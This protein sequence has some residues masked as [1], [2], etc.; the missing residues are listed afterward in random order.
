MFDQVATALMVGLAPTPPARS[1][2]QRRVTLWAPRPQ[3]VLGALA[4]LLAVA[5]FAYLA[6]TASQQAFSAADL[7]IARWVRALDLPGLNA[8]FLPPQLLPGRS[9]SVTRRAQTRPS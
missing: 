5:G 1:T 7:A 9:Q 3:V 8:T 4:I 6:L 2:V